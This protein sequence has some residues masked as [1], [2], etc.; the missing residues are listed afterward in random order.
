MDLDPHLFP[1]AQLC[2]APAA[3]E[4]ATPEGYLADALDA[5]LAAGE[6]E[7]PVRDLLDALPGGIPLSLEVRSAHY[8]QTYPEPAAR[9]RAIREATERFLTDYLSTPGAGS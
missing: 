4:A 9:A 1:Y 5:R 2:D 7:L 8:R 6:A 3:V